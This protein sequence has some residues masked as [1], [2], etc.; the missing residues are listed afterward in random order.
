MGGGVGILGGGVPARPRLFGRHGARPLRRAIE[1]YFLAPLAATLVEHRFPEGDQF[2]FVRSDGAGIQIDFVDP[3]AEPAPAGPAAAAGLAAP[4]DAPPSDAAALTLG[5]IILQ[6]TG[7]AAERHCLRSRIDAIAAALNSSAWLA[8][9][10]RLAGQMQAHDFWER[11]DRFVVLARYAL[12]DRV[13]AAHETAESLWMRLE[14][15]VRGAQY[16]RPIASRIALQTYLLELGIADGLDGQVDDALLTVEAVLDG[17]QD[18]AAAAAWCAELNGMYE[19]WAAA[20]HMQC[21]TLDGMRAFGDSGRCAYC[22]ARR[23]CT[24]W[25][26]TRTVDAWW[27][28]STWRRSRRDRPW[29][30]CA[31]RPRPH[32][33]WRPVRAVRT[34][35]AATAP[36]PRRSRAMPWRAG[37]PGAWI[38]C[39]A[40]TSTCWAI[41]RRG[42]DRALY[43]PDDDSRRKEGSSLRHLILTISAISAMSAMS[44]LSAAAADYSTP[45][46]ALESL[47][48]AYAAKNIEAAIAARDFDAEAREVMHAME[49]ENPNFK[50]DED[51]TRRLHRELEAGYRA[52]I[53]AKGFPDKSTLRCGY[54]EQPPKRAGLVPVKESCVAPDGTRSEE[55]DFAVQTSAGWKIIS[56]PNTGG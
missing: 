32:G 34:S 3:D 17:G 18:P 31:G 19:K 12:L 16:A 7:S 23:V 2:L 36:A 20:R 27:P 24:S 55:T 28:A 30:R 48:A 11:D 39:S 29:R 21:V 4:A 54:A 46:A 33:S 49:L 35:C 13:K 8:Q 44:A 25:I 38:C 15:S 37:A 6:P 51:M 26:R 22:N 53:A 9:K 47:E 14:R 45:T 5:G 10:D 52:E 42:P 43:N 1:E 41:W 50:A 40:A 56:L